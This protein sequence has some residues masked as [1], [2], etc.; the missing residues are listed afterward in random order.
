MDGRA[1]RKNL[2]DMVQAAD[3][4]TPGYIAGPDDRSVGSSKRT[5]TSTVVSASHG[6]EGA[7]GH[8]RLTGACE[9]ARIT[10]ELNSARARSRATQPVRP[11]LSPATA[12][13]PAPLYWRVRSMPAVCVVWRQG[14]EPSAM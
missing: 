11:P 8:T 4:T 7:S 2:S 10:S 12:P 1:K 3:A 14:S 9:H 13:R 5:R 6:E